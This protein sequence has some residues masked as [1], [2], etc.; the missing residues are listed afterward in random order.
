[1]KSSACRQIGRVDGSRQSR[2][3]G[4]PRY[5]NFTAFPNA[6]IAKSYGRVG[7][8][9]PRLCTQVMRLGPTIPATAWPRKGSRAGCHGASVKVSSRRMTAILPVGVVMA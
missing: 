9:L 8:S 4:L 2:A 6:V 7:S 5:S 1:M 3:Q